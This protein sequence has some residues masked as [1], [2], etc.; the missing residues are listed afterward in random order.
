MGFGYLLLGYL[1]WLNPVYSGFTEW[2]AVTLMLSGLNKL[3]PYGKGFKLSSWLGVPLLIASICNLALNCCDI[4]GVINYSGG[5]L[6][7][8]VM[9]VLLLLGFVFKLLVLWGIFEITGFT[10]IDNLKLRSVYCFVLYVFIYVFKILISFR[11]ITASAYGFPVILFGE[12]IVGLIAVFLIFACLRRI[13]LE[14]EEENGKLQAET[15]KQSWWQ[16]VKDMSGVSDVEVE[17]NK[18]SHNKRKN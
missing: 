12:L 3:S 9:T 17:N 11:L 16:R 2:L 1:I 14:G 7:N 8:A 13:G 5:D 18:N 4:L 15:K 10:G 6:Y